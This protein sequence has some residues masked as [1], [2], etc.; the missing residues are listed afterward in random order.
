MG[1]MFRDLP[2]VS[3]RLKELLNKNKPELVFWSSASDYNIYLH[4]GC[5][6]THEEMVERLGKPPGTIV[7][8]LNPYVRSTNWMCDFCGRKF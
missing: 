3:P 8:G 2:P 4:K 7:M 6:V 1:S 5:P